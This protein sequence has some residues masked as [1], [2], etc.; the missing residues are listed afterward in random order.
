LI[1]LD[2]IGQTIRALGHLPEESISPQALESLLEQ[3]R[4]WH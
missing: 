1:Y 4:G 3:F 2:Q